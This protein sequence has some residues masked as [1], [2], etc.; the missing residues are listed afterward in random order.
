VKI[1]HTLIIALLGAALLLWWFLNHEPETRSQAE[2]KQSNEKAVPAPSA[3][4]KREVE[5][6]EPQQSVVE[7]SDQPAHEISRVNVAFDPDAEAKSKI[8]EPYR[9]I[10]QG[11]GAAKIVDKSGKVVLEADP[12]VGIY[13][14]SV[15]PDGEHIAVDCASAGSIILEPKTGNKITLPKRPPGENKFVFESWYWIDDNTLVAESGDHKLDVLGRPVKSD[16]N[17][18]QSRL[19][20]YSLNQKQLDEVQLPKDLGAKVFSIAYVSSKGYVHLVTDDPTAT[21]A[22]DLGWFELRPK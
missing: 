6:P 22:P 21:R 20:L 5:Q 12:K 17:V 15:S 8:A 7:R 4:E 13:G 10:G 14:C 2:R 18:S 9:L 19:Y 1:K 11:S 3:N 16:D